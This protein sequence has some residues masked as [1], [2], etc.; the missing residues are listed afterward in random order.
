MEGELILLFLVLG[1]VFLYIIHQKTQLKEQFELPPR[2]VVS[3]TTTPKRI[4]L[5]EPTIQSL[6]KQTVLPDRIYLNIPERSARTGGPYEIPAFLERYPL[7]KVNH[8]PKDEGPITK[9][10]PAVRAESNPETIIIICDDDTTY[11]P[12]FI[13]RFVDLYKNPENSNTVLANSCRN[14]FNPAPVPQCDYPEGWS[15]VAF[16]RKFFHSDFE[17]YLKKALT[18]KKCF[19]S[20]DL[21]I[22]NYLDLHA[23]PRIR[24]GYWGDELPHAK[25]AD[26]LQVMDKDG[27]NRYRPCRQFLLENG[28]YAY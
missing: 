18:D 12:E 10:A 6:V 25:D 20:D 23:V 8:V 3:F 2:I 11:V 15:G 24:L 22:G 7:V 4:H 17:D 27:P 16:K 26:A 14:D 28:L 5:I 13:Q 1:I 19:T 21:L 9:L